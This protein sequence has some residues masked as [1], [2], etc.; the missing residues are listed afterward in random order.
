M[1]S[2]FVLATLVLLVVVLVVVTGRERRLSQ[3]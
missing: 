3:V 1:K 2:V